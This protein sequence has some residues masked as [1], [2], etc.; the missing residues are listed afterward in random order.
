MLSSLTDDPCSGLA[1]V[2]AGLAGRLLFGGFAL[3]S[4]FRFPVFFQVPFALVFHADRI[5]Q[6]RGQILGA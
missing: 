3:F 5:T 4:G 2:F 1:E 6:S